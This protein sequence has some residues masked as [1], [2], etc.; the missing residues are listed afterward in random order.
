M[1]VVCGCNS[2]DAA[3]ET[4][5]PEPETERTIKLEA[6]ILGA[7]QRLA[8]RNRAHFF[9]HR[10]TAYN[11][12]SSPGSGKTTLLCATIDALRKR[13]PD[14]PLAVMYTHM[15]TTTL[16]QRHC[17]SLKTWAIWCAPPCGTWVKPPRW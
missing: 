14:L 3:T 10:V 2:S 13:A 5:A 6:D 17:C 1:C 16:A 12:V 7:N 9:A 11:L 15:N 4:V 8:D